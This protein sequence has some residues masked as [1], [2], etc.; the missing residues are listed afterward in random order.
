[1]LTGVII[2]LKVRKEKETLEN[3]NADALEA[4]RRLG[5]VLVIYQHRHTISEKELLQEAIKGLKERFFPDKTW[6]EIFSSK[7]KNKTPPTQT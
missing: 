7:N 6:K 3:Q 4:I 1:L 2:I 5:Y